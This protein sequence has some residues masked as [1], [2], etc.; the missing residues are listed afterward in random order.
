MGGAAG[1]AAQIGMG[2]LQM[3]QGM[4]EAKAMKQQAEFNAKQS[5]FNASLVK[6]QQEDLQAESEEAVFQREQQ[7]NQMVGSQKVSLAAQGIEVEG[8]IGETL[9]QE[10]RLIGLEDVQAIKNNA[11]RESMGL[12][13]KKQDMLSSAKAMRIEGESR[14]NARK[15]QGMMSGA[16]SMLRGASQMGDDKGFMSKVAK[17]GKRSNWDY[18]YRKKSYKGGKRVPYNYSEGSSRGIS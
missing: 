16:G 18:T 5:E 17:M 7:I 6:Y 11:W 2:G 1:G 12:E 14:A 8:E 10:E 3:V 4:E 13:I 15:M 9:E